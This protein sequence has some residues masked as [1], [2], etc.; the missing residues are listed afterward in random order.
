[1]VCFVFASV[2][3]EVLPVWN[4]MSVWLDTCKV[5]FVCT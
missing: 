1:V 4:M 5:L 3:L 2:Y